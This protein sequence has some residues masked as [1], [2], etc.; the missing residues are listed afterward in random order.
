[1]G[2]YDL[3][4][5]LPLL[6]KTPDEQQQWQEEQT[7]KLIQQWALDEAD[8]EFLLQ[9]LGLRESPPPLKPPRGP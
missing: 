2:N 9:I 5:R 3:V 7:E 4:D 8:C 6:G 1:M